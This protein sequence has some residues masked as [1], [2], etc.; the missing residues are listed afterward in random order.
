MI[1]A[2]PAWQGGEVTGFDGGAVF[3]IGAIRR[4]I[5]AP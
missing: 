3:R 2:L 5:V 4:R 1:L